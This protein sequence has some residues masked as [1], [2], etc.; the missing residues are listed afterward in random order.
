MS[1]TIANRHGVHVRLPWVPILAV[2]ATAIIAA[3][4]LVLVNQPTSTRTESGTAAAAITAVQ[5][6]SVPKPENPAFRRQLAEQ[7]QAQT[8]QAAQAQWR[9]MHSHPEGTTLDAIGTGTL[10]APGVKTGVVVHT[11]NGLSHFPGRIPGHR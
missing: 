9:A 8:P 11:H 3:A 5:S 7:A 10:V 2:L 1:Q 4:V 6:A